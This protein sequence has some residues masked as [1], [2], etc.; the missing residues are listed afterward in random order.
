MLA[1][2]P[3]SVHALSPSPPII[4]V[5]SSHYGSANITDTSLIAGSNFYV[6]VNVT[7][8]PVAWNGYE[9]ALYYD[10]RYINV[11]SYDFTTGTVFPN[12]F[13]S[14]ATYNGPGALR[15]SVYDGGSVSVDSGMLVNITFQVVNAGGVSSLV[16]GAGMTNPGGSA[17][18]PPSICLRC[19]AQSPNWSRLIAGQTLIAVQ[20]SDGYFKNVANSSGPVASF[21]YSPL[22]PAQGDTITF[23]ATRSL[24]PDNSNAANQGIAEYL[25]DFGTATTDGNTSTVSP[26]LAHLFAPSGGAG[27]VALNGNFSVRL[28]VLDR[29]NGFEGMQVQL[30]SIAPPPSHCVQVSGIFAKTQVNPG[31][32]EKVGVQVTNAGTYTEKFNVTVTYG[33]PYVTL[34]PVTGLTL[35]PGKITTYPLNITTTNLVPAVYNI[36]VTITLYGNSNCEAGSSVS[37]FAVVAQNSGNPAL[38][39]VGGI[40]VVIA[41]I[42]VAGLFLRTRRK[43]EPD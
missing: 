12:P 5:F 34:A 26:I 1:V 27:G 20:T 22:N 33:P 17:G 42:V 32:P 15:L 10:Q 4:G 41:I 35:G 14:P 8:A 18:A 13:S 31:T 23:N 3:V 43:P 7:N 25:W 40:V 6:Q 30:L 19:P 21:T 28:T 36:A 39:L 29:D 11:V 16:L 9:F 24:D 38:V 2:L 37:Q